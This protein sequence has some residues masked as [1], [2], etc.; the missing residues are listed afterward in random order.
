MRI[1]A[2]GGG[3]GGHVTPVAAVIAELKKIRPDT[4]IR[5]WCDRKFEA[6]AKATMAHY[7]P[8]LKVETIVAGKFRR[9]HKLPLWQQLVHFRTIGFPNLVD[10]VKTIVGTVES[11]Y[12]LLRWRPDVVFTKGGCV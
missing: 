2:V 10:F 4:E 6:Q 1:L 7:H 5:F 3:S 12:K 8:D 11:I 9:Y